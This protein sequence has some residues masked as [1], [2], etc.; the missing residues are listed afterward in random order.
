MEG[1]FYVSGQPIDHAWREYRGTGNAETVVCYVERKGDQF[2]RANLFRLVLSKKFFF[3]YFYVMRRQFLDTSFL[4]FFLPAPN[5]VEIFQ[6]DWLSPRVAFV[7][8]SLITTWQFAA[9]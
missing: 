4:Y 5:L 7:L 6:N 8:Q 1:R 2:C 3:F 9:F